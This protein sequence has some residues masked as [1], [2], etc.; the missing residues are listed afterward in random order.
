MSPRREENGKDRVWPMGSLM[1]PATGPI[2]S[3]IT[4]VS[5]PRK[6]ET[7]TRVRPGEEEMEAGEM[8]DGNRRR[9]SAHPAG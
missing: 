3:G 1:C 2:P 8:A 9:E 6:G 5:R 7:M 4:I